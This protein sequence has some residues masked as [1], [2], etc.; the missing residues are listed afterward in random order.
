M[1]VYRLSQRQCYHLGAE[2]E[3]TETMTRAHPLQQEKGWQV[4]EP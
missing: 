4:S 2:I 3:S 1:A